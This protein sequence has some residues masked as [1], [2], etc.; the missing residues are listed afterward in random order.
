MTEISDYIRKGWRCY[1]L[2]IIGPFTETKLKY[3]YYRLGRDVIADKENNLL[4]VK[5]IRE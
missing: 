3:I 5:D 2:S 4:F 1:P